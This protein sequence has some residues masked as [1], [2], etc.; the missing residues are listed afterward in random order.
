MSIDRFDRSKILPLFSFSL[1]FSPIRSRNIVDAHKNRSGIKCMRPKVGAR[2]IA[3]NV[4]PHLILTPT[5]TDRVR[6]FHSSMSLLGPIT[7]YFIVID[8]RDHVVKGKHLCI[9]FWNESIIDYEYAFESTTYTRYSHIEYI[10]ITSIVLT[11]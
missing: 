6:T 9:S 5:L 4:L 3:L 10:H 2:H 7:I 1:S 8:S 11:R